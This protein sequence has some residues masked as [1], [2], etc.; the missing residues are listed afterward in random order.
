M[1]KKILIF[2]ASR[3]EYGIL[4]SVIIRLKNSKHFDT[5]ILVTGTHLIKKF[6]KTIKEIRQD[7]FKSLIK[8]KTLKEHTNKKNISLAISQGIKKISQYF[9]KNRPDLVILV[10]DR[11]ELY[12][13]AI[14]SVIYNV[15]IC[16][17]HGGEATYGVI[18]DYI[19]HS[20]TKMSTFHCATNQIYKKR[21]IQMGEDPK[22][23]IYS[24]APSIDILK[25]MKFNKK[26]DLEKYLKISFLKKIFVITY[27]PLTT[28]KKKTF[29]GIINL[30]KALKKFKNY[31][32]IFTLP[33]F[34]DNAD[35]IIKKIK[36]FCKK[37][38]NCHFYKSLGHEKYLSLVKISD[39]V[40]GNSSSG[41]I[42]VPYLNIPTINIGNRQNGREMPK[43]VFT[44]NTDYLSILRQIK[45]VL[46]FKDPKKLFKKR[47]YGNGNASL[48]IINFLKKIKINNYISGKKFNDFNF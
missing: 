5:K 7:K 26:E 19:R 40:I 1:K 25:K 30:L 17:I 18:D 9:E 45:K 32:I 8:I 44:T 35:L 10:G 39:L 37:N 47:I 34:D 13:I 15:P 33:N 24:G 16:H 41:V 6:G 21:I 3:S 4:K 42:E 11:Y 2:T 23:I 29:I 28:S 38:K 36:L 31:T 48:K 14:T 43:S 27:H 22:N 12:S 46:K 20:I